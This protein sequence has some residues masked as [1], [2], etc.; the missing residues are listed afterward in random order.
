MT[1]Q[2]RCLNLAVGSGRGK[3]IPVTLQV[4]LLLPST[5]YES[6]TR[7]KSH[8]VNNPPWNLC[9]RSITEPFV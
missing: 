5:P 2:D 7:I 1:L 9:E 6:L 4:T 8:A 3:S